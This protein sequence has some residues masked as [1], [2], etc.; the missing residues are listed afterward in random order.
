MVSVVLASKASV[1]VTSTPASGRS[2][3]ASHCPFPPMSRMT[4]TVSSPSS[5]AACAAAG[6]GLCERGQRAAHDRGEGTGTQHRQRR[7]AADLSR[8]ETATTM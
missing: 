1:T 4:R 8:R 3:T 2:I 7:E 6:A 5:L